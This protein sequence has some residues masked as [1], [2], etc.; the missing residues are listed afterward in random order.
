MLFAMKAMVINRFGG[1]E[2]FELAE[3]PRPEPKPG[4]LLIKVA[5]SSVNPVDTKIR[6]GMLAQLSPAFPA[7]LHGDVAGTVDAVGEGV[8]NFKAG[9]A[10]YACAG[11]FKGLQGALAEYMLADAALVARKPE[12]LG[13]AEAA[14]LPLVGITAW[15]A[16]IERAQI[17]PGQRVLVQGAAGGVGHIGVQLAKI[18]GAIVYGTVSTPAKA[19]IA[20]KVGADYVIF[21]REKRPAE[22]V[23]E[24]TGGEGFDV[25]FDTVGGDSLAASFQAVKPNGTVVTIAAR[26]TQD[27]SP[28]HAKNASLLVVFML[29]PIL[30]PSERRR[31]GMILERLTRL[32]DHGRLQPVLDAEHFSFTRVAD[33]HRKLEQNRMIGK[34]V[35]EARWD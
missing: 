11:G 6:S 10:V 32:V 33:A 18:A 25:V 7:I 9:D 23:K 2:V 13:M 21:Y 15:E 34:I 5:A 19:E 22:Y 16:L 31:H 14:A 35:L 24:F 29:L 17:R 8:D 1:P 12:K 30:Q 28:M 3:L 4:H 26:S 27:L 20:R